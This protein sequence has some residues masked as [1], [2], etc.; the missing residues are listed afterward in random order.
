MNNFITRTLS[1]IVYAGVVVAS[2]LVQPKCFG[3]HMLLFGVVFMIVS[4]LAIREF[5]SLVGGSD[6]KIQ[7]Y[8]MIAN[9]LLFC[10]LYF[11]FYGDMIW[12]PLLFA[13]VA[14]LL[15]AMIVHLFREKV[16][17]V[18]SWGNLCA[19]QLMI[20]LPFALMSGVVLYNKWLM[21]ALFI[22]IWVND[23]GA[24]IV[25]S[26]MSKRK[27]GNHKMFPRVSPAKSW[28]GLI[29]GF[30][31]DLIAGYI[32]YL[33]GWTTTMGLTAYPLLDSLLFAL[34]VGVFGTLGDLMESLMK[35]TIGV[36]DSGKFMPGH[37]GVLDRFD[38]LLLA[39]PVVYFL[40]I[41]LPSIL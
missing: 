8:A 27:G 6:V 17:A 13:Y 22:L 35:R 5:H 39:V 40:F 37:G 3:N 31:F 26:L 23:S 29:G 34:I 33:V 1:A 9:S 25:G 2:I 21:F 4:T 24:Y 38:S 32:F 7:S 36:K 19:G 28:E 16:N 41:Y 14:I 18:E 20:A 10:T 15:L 30:V 11:L 12:R